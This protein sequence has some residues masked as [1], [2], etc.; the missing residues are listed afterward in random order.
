MAWVIIANAYGGDWDKAD[1]EWKEAAERWRDRHY[2]GSVRLATHDV[3]DD[4]LLFRVAEA[5][6]RIV[7]PYG[8]LGIPTYAPYAAEE[9]IRL[10]R[11]SDSASATLTYTEAHKALREGD[12]RHYLGWL[13]GQGY[14][15]VACHSQGA[16]S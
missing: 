15:V 4:T 9:A 14:A 7:G 2:I 3:S 6:V 13:Y 5:I 8:G 1:P 16:D 11:A 10:V 12:I